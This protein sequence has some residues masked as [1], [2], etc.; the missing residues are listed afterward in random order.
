MGWE[1]RIREIGTID[2]IMGH[3]TQARNYN[4]MIT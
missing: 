1:G 3:D 2:G 4:D